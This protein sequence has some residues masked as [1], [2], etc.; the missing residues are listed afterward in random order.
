MKKFIRIGV[1][2]GKKYYAL[3]S[4]G[5]PPVTRKLPPRE[6]AASTSCSNWRKRTRRFRTPPGQP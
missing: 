5:G 6:S 1:D 2:L 4:E 3:A